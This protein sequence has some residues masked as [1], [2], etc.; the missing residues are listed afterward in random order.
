MKFKTERAE[1]LVDNL[2]LVEAAQFDSAKWEHFQIAHLEDDS[3]FRIEVKSRQIAWS[4]LI[5]CE[6]VANAVLYGISSLF[7]S[8][9]LDEAQEKIVYAKRVYE[10]LH[11]QGL[12]KIAVPNTTTALGFDNGARIMSLPGTPNRGKANFWVY[13]DEWAHQR[14]AHENYT[15]ILPVISKGGMFRGASSPMGAGGMFWEIYSQAFMPYP[16]YYR[17]ST[18][19]WE[20][21]AFCNNVREARKLAPTLPTRQR[22]ELFGNDRIKVIHANMPEED[23]QQEYECLFVDETTAWITWDEI[24]ANQALHNGTAVLSHSKDSRVDGA[25]QAIDRLAHLVNTQKVELVLS[26]GYD[27]GRTRNTSELFINGISTLRS[28]P[29]RGAITLDNCDFDSQQSVLKYAMQ[30]LPIFALLID[31]NG[32]G[33]NLAENMEKAYPGKAIGAAFTNLS[34]MLWATDGKMLFQ[35]NRVPIPVDKD[36]AYQIHSIKRIVTPAKNLVFDTEKAE[37]HHAD[38]FWALMLSLAAAVQL[39]SEPNRDGEVLVDDTEVNISP[40]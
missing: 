35:Q 23:F 24:K 9:S 22:V 17:K 29:L 28:F 2:D 39:T 40:Y 16:G 31:R 34:K 12:P 26:A 19:W 6:A 11:V 1:F 38:K 36:I 32:I 33:M 14:Y 8:I 37:K 7:Q 15:A 13:L 27:V 4:F 3:T 30:K 10:N 20:I 5:A 21:Q 25:F 18:P